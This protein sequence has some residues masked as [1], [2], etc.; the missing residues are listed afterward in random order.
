MYLIKPISLKVQDCLK[1][2]ISFDENLTFEQRK[3]NWIEGV[4]DTVL[5]TCDSDLGCLHVF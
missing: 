3:T 5:C 1:H 4:V 2:I